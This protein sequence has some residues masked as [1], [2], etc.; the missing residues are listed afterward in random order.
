MDYAKPRQHLQRP[1]HIEQ[2]RIGASSRHSKTSDQLRG[3]SAGL[4]VA[5]CASRTKACSPAM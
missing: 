2:L 4:L 5:H 3:G 1:R